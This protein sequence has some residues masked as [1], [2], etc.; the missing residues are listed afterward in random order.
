MVDINTRLLARLEDRAFQG[1]L[2]PKEIS[3]ISLEL[4]DEDQV[5]L[6][7]LYDYCSLAIDHSI[8][9][10]VQEDD[11]DIEKE[12][13]VIKRITLLCYEVGCKNKY[14]QILKEEENNQ[15]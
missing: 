15:R 11:P 8:K 3:E 5:D 1:K 2:N 7:L 12:S 6:S 4:C 10:I 9:R 13:E 14:L